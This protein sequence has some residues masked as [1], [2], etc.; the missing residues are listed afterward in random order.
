MTIKLRTQSVVANAPRALCFEVVA[1]AGR[2]IAETSPTD[3]IVEFKT[4][5]RGREVVTVEKLHLEPA[6]R[7]DYEWIKGPLPEVRESIA[8]TTDGDNRTRITYD[9]VFDVKGGLFGRIIARLSIKPAFER[10]VLEHLEEAKDIAE[11]RARRSHVHRQDN[12]DPDND[13]SRTGGHT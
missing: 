4:T 12:S 1:A 13:P 2:V 11:R 5:Y 10:I 3:R 9:G 7:I 6:T 8:F